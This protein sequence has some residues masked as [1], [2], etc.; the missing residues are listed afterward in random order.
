MPYSTS[1]L[2]KLAIEEHLKYSEFPKV[3]AV[4]AKQGSVLAT[5]YRGEVDKTNAELIA[6]EKL[7]REELAI[8]LWDV[9]MVRTILY[10]LMHRCPM[11]KLQDKSHKP[12]EAAACL[13]VHAAASLPLISVFANIGYD[14]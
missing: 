4:V 8:K 2:M 14:V 1:N 3:G 6:I 11:L 13:A 7:T 9:T 12:N 5:G 10:R